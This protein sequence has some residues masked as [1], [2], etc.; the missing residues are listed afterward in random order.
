[1]WGQSRYGVRVWLLFFV[2]AGAAFA[3]GTIDGTVRD[4]SGAA[5]PNSNVAL[6][7]DESKAVAAT[8]TTDS[9]GKFR[10]VAVDG[11]EYTLKVDR[12]GYYPSSV[13]FVLR[14]RQPLS[15]NVD[16][17]RKETVRERV[18]VQAKYLT[19]DPEKTGSSY[20]FTRQRPGSAAGPDRGEHER[21]GE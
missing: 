16:V 2:A 11:G 19:I 18:E 10:F 12:D 7:R 8:T 1:M 20:V 3:Q 17:D 9:A 6:Q 5:V 14:A 21:P 13:Q 4:R 15:V